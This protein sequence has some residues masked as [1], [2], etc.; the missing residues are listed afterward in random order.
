MAYSSRAR[1]C[2][3]SVCAID[4]LSRDNGHNILLRMLCGSKVFM[5]TQPSLWR[6]TQNQL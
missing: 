1:T 4:H 2:A 3:D 5:Q 6:T